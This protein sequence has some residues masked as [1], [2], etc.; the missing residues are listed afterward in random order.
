MEWP[1]TTSSAVGRLDGTLESLGVLLR[2]RVTTQYLR[3]SHWAKHRIGAF[4]VACEAETQLVWQV[5]KGWARRH[6]QTTEEP[7]VRKSPETAD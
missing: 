6:P 5:G 3:L 4:A 1:R 2:H 7:T